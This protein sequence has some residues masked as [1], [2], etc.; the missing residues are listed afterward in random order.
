[1]PTSAFSFG[2]SSFAVFALALAAFVCFAVAFPHL[3]LSAAFFFYITRALVFEGLNPSLI[4]APHVLPDF[5][6]P[7]R[8]LLLLALGFLQLVDATLVRHGLPP[9]Q[10]FV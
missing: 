4:G 6:C 9:E 1:M 7:L 3:R 2:F 5:F 8:V 10:L